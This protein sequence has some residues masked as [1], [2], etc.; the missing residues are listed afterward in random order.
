MKYLHNYWKIFETKKTEEEGLKVLQKRGFETPQ[1][2]L[3]TI[4]KMSKD[5]LGDNEKNMVAMC[6]L[7][8][9][10]NNIETIISTTFKEYSDLVKTNKIK[11]LAVSG[12]KVKI[13]NN[14]FDEGEIIKF[15]EFIH[16][17]KP[18]VISGEKGTINFNTKETPIWEGNNIEIYDGNSDEKEEGKDK[19][20]RYTGANVQPGTL[21]GKKYSFCIGYFVPNN[22]W[23]S[24]RDTKDSTFYFIVDKN[25]D[26]SDPLHMVV[27]DNTKYGVELTDENNNTGRIAEYGTN[28]E[29]YVKYLKSK[30]VPVDTLLVHKTKTQKEIEDEKILGRKNENLEWFQKLPIEYRSRYVGRGHGLADEQFDWL[31]ATPSLDR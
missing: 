27:Y 21:T 24:Y 20:I 22:M 26:F 9:D 14:G 7:W 10:I 11:P 2:I 31:M 16:A 30:G 18:K 12:N 13:D 25:K 23:Q 19:C 28:V 29:D 17:N 1:L 3:D 6:V 15:Q 8:A 5:S 4:K